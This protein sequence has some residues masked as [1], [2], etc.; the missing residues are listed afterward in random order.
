[1]CIQTS[2]QCKIISTC[3]LHNCCGKWEGWDP[4]NRFKHTNWVAIRT[5]TDGPKSVRDCCV[6]EIVG[7]FF[8]LSRCLL[9]F[10]GC[11][12]FCNRTESDL[13][14]FLFSF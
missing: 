11:R 14:L 7:G 10:S 9:D 6:I 5:P 3:E 8:V 13:F 2:S 1:M 12:G 4:I